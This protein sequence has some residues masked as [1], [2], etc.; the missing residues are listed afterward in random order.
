MLTICLGTWQLNRLSWKENLIKTFKE[1]S[2]KTPI[3][4][5]LSEKT[6]FL[7]IKVSGQINRKYKIFYPAK[8]L[9]GKSGFRL[10]SV[11][12]T[13]QGENFL[14]DEGWYANENHQYF[15]KNDK[16]FNKEIIGYVRYPRDAKFFTP[17]NNFM[18]NEWYTYNLK[19]IE[20]YLDVKIN[21]KYFIKNMSDSEEAFLIPSDLTPTFR[22]N[23]LQYAITWFVMS[24]AFFVLFL[25]YLKKNKC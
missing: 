1:T 16:I 6:E 12:K 21:Q 20:E 10:A 14:I 22:N 17:K 3:D 18:T 11:I 5:H 7:K 8:T 24:F 19:E 9:N 23:H 25:V 15:L 4:L 2:S 13:I